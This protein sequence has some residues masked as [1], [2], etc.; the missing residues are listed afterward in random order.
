MPYLTLAKKDVESFMKKAGVTV[1]KNELDAF[2]KAL[3]GRDVVEA[4]KKGETMLVS[5]PAGGG[6]AA[7]A[8]AAAAPK[9]AAAAKE[10]PKKEEEEEV[11]MGGLFGDDDEY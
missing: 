11:D 4:T 2:F 1:E 10:E 6:G 8:K 5:M 9:E 7:P 3:E